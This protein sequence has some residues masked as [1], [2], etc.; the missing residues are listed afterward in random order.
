MRKTYCSHS[1]HQIFLFELGLSIF[2]WKKNFKLKQLWIMNHSYA[3]SAISEQ[4]NGKE[5]NNNKNNLPTM[6]AYFICGKSC[7]FMLLALPSLI[8][9]EEDWGGIA[10]LGV[11]VARWKER[12]RRGERF[13]LSLSP[14]F[15]PLTQPNSLAILDFP[16]IISHGS[17]LHEQNFYASKESAFNA[18]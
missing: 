12:G 9:T 3:K 8:I 2:R 11:G 13:S 5:T 1:L 4:E 10:T 14:S 18:G 16:W 17:W 7:L 6:Q 15:L